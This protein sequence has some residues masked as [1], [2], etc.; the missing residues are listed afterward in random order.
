MRHKCNEIDCEIGKIKYILDW[1]KLRKKSVYAM[2]TPNKI[3]LIIK[4]K[5]SL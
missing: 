1:V 4:I 5:K 3:G 2:R